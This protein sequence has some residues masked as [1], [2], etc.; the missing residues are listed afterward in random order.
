MITI[1]RS[2]QVQQPAFAQMSDGELLACVVERRVEAFEE[3]YQ[4]YAGAIIAI[5]RQFAVDSA[6]A[7]EATQAAFL[8]LWERAQNLEPDSRLR[9]WL[10]TVARN[11]AIS[12][13]R[14]KRVETVPL[15][16]NTDAVLDQP[17]PEDYAIMNERKRDIRA[18]LDTLPQDQRRVIELTYF[19]GLSQSEIALLVDE[20][21]GTIKSRVRLAM[22]RLRALMVGKEAKHEPTFDTGA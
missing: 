21:L 13:R 8:A 16:A 20:P 7:N 2:S 12:E 5:V 3:L 6:D 18:A 14:R 17:T 19:G 1:T 22:Q 4:R 10:A 9:S 11:N 15:S